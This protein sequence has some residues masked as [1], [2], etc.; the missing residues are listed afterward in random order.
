MVMTSKEI[1][2][3]YKRELQEEVV[4]VRSL[5]QEELLLSLA[6]RTVKG[7]DIYNH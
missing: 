1:G 6:C 2:T 7:R 4:E 5:S 3:G